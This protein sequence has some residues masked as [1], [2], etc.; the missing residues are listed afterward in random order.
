MESDGE[1]TTTR[2]EQMGTEGKAALR[3]AITRTTSYPYHNPNETDILIPTGLST[4]CGCE[5]SRI[6][7]SYRAAGRQGS[8][9][10][11]R[12]DPRAI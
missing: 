6:T 11:N 5:E 4:I 1:A 8:R 2:E 10:L 9:V 12:H 3:L 7:A